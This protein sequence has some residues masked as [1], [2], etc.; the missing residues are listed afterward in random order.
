MKKALI[1]FPDE[2]I[3]YSPTVL[4][5]IALLKN[6]YEIHVISI[7]NGSCRQGRLTPNHKI[8]KINNF[9]SKVLI[10]INCYKLFKFLLLILN[11]LIK[12]ISV[13]K[14]DFILGI[15]SVG[16]ASGKLF[17]KNTIY[18]SLEIK[19]DFYFHLSKLQGVSD[20][21]IQTCERRDYLFNG[22]KVNTFY[23]PNSPNFN[24]KELETSRKKD[25][26]LF[27]NI[28]PENGTESCILALEKLPVEYTL[29]LKGIISERYSEYL[30]KEYK[31][32]GDR[33]TIDSTYIEQDYVINY[34]DKF[35]IG[36]CF[37]DLNLIKNVDFNYISSPSGKLYNYYAAG[38]PVIAN[39]LIGLKSV[40]QFEAGKV[41]TDITP[42]SIV[43]SILDIDDN[44]LF[45]QL[46]ALQAAQEFDFKKNFTSILKHYSLK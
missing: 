29:T 34:L 44:Y 46:N 22:K 3:L 39:D 16:Y 35:L 18:L 45:Y 42:E 23:L 32:L 12:K 24:G 1:I 33:F 38:V 25:L 26:I 11:L 7:D 37:Y 21:I 6:E 10:R 41:I 40:Q 36:F 31:F 5:S 2:W 19:K 27:G 43:Q 4:N 14:Y 17:F 20:L 8:I 28:L 30:R 15:D 13:N 9:I